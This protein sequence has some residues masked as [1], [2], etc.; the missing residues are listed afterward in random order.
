MGVFNF[1]PY[2]AV[3]YLRTS[4]KVHEMTAYFAVI[5][6][7]NDASQTVDSNY[8]LTLGYFKD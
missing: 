8:E 5:C 3:G 7:A 1:L 4:N 2:L 6:F